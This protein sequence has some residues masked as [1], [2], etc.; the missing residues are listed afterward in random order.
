MFKVMRF[1][2]PSPSSFTRVR[3][4]RDSG[5][6]GLITGAR[7]S[8]SPLFYTLRHEFVAMVTPILIALILRLIIKTHFFRLFELNSLT[9]D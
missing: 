5:K 3:S 4:K 6:Y 1:G 2:G 9:G 8:P 7:A